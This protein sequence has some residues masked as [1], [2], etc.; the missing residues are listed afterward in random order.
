MAVRNTSYRSDYFK[1][2]KGLFGVLH[3]CYICRKPLTRKYVEVDHIIPISKTLG[4]NSSWNL[5]SLC[6]KCN[7]KKS[8]KQ[9]VRVLMGL[10]TKIVN[11]IISIPFVLLGFVFSLF[12]KLNGKLKVL[13]IALAVLYLW[14]NG[15]INFG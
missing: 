11:T 1:N 14:V 5:G 15:F 8:N 7:R 2:N 3:F 13:V 10:G 9:D 4:S 6:K 12:S